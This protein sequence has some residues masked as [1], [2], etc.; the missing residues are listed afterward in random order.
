MFE[1]IIG[2]ALGALGSLFG[3]S[4]SKDAAEDASERNAHLQR[5]FAQHGIRWRV[6]DAKAAGVHPLYA[7]GSGVTPFSPS[8]SVGGEGSGI[9]EAM[10]TMG[11][12]VARAVA[13]QETALERQERQARIGLIEAQADAAS[14]Q[15][16]YYRSNAVNPSPQ[17][18]PM[19]GVDF[20]VGGGAQALPYRP[21]DMPKAIQLQH[22]ND[23][24]PGRFGV[25]GPKAQEIV[26]A[27]P[28]APWV[29]AGP[30]Q[31]GYGAY[32]LTRNFEML[33]PLN[34][35]GWS[36]G[37]ESVPMSMWPY[38]IKANVDHY[39]PEWKR[40][41][42]SEWIRGH[43]A[44]P[45]VLADMVLR[46]TSPGELPADLWQQVKAKWFSSRRGLDLREGQYVPGV[47]QIRR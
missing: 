3:A 41:A 6:A 26:S 28:A 42:L 10:Q 24:F 44:M 25:V 32:K 38:V 35:E 29:A 39:G 2:G 47:S 34:D 9:G 1:S 4:E 17:A 21:V 46:Y 16:Q 22:G 31:P 5:E 15:A 14:A 12:S 19:A 18:A 27:N 13:A 23:D 45:N 37:L 30:A 8:V 20:E 36:E 33:V 7:L 11:Q 43:P 40:M